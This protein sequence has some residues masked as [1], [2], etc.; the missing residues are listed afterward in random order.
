M[1][2]PIPKK[3]PGNTVFRGNTEMRKSPNENNTEGIM[4]QI[5]D[6]VN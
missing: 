3:E 2:Q 4:T 6:T 5:R 1:I